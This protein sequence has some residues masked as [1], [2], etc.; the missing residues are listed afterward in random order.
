MVWGNNVKYSYQPINTNLPLYNLPDKNKQFPFKSV[1]IFKGGISLKNNKLLTT[2]KKEKIWITLLEDWDD[3]N[4]N[5][6][7]FIK[8]LCRRGIPKTIRGK[9]WLHLIKVSDKIN[10]HSFEN[11]AG[12][13]KC[14]SEI[15]KDLNR[16]Y[17]N[18]EMFSDSSPYGR[19]GQKNL[20]NIL[21]GYTILFPDRGYCQAQAPIAALLLIQMPPEDAF[22]LF[23]GICDGIA[24]DYYSD[25]LE[26]LQKEG[27]ILK[28][29]LK[30]HLPKIYTLFEKHEVEPELYMV[31][32]FL[33]LYSRTFPINVV[34]RLWDV[35]F[36]EGHKIIFKTALV[37]IKHIFMKKISNPD[38]VTILQRFKKIPEYLLDGDYLISEIS[39]IS[40]EH[41]ELIQVHYNM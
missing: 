41:Y 7:D 34:L 32:W 2:E 21:K 6:Y 5:N 38:T 9:V 27:K 33:C 3:Y 14:V 1:I 8:T 4:I 22:K 20:F 23:I 10:L 35:L 26:R 39:K 15:S 18:H 24:K 31:E 30:I 25:N 17:P 16:Q 36:C 40:I 28:S 13:S 29:L 11:M 12:N 19:Q 37:L